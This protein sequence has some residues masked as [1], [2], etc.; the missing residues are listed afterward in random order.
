M[1]R[2]P[3]SFDPNVL[4]DWVEASLIATA[5]TGQ[6]ISETGI[7]NEF[8]RSDAP[9]AEENLANIRNRVSKRK[10]YL[11]A[12]YPIH[13]SKRM[14]SLAKAHKS[15]L[16]YKFLLLA[17]LN[18]SYGDLKYSAGRAAK[19]AEMF[20]ELTCLALKKYLGGVAIRMGAPRRSPVP[21]NFPKAVLYAAEQLGEEFRYGKMELQ[22]SGDDGVDVIAWKPFGDNRSSQLV[23]L[24]QCAIGTDWAKKRSELEL[25]V[26]ANHIRWDTG[27]LKAFSVPF[28][29]DTGGTWAE[30]AAR[31]GVILDRTRLTSI[32]ASG[33]IQAAFRKKIS[34][35]CAERITQAQTLNL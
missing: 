12:S 28:A 9:E 6:R 30:T 8:A 35:W 4:T 13:F 17:S 32:L 21:S 15:C 29:I 22:Q 7:L 16:L 26:W 25:K 23:I 33:D 34:K 19:P 27:P 5:V 10:A 24:A 1:L 11:G 20:E 18:Q 14:F 3:D 2:L 31:G